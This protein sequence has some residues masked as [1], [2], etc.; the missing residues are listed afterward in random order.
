MFGTV[1]RIQHVRNSWTGQSYRCVAI[2]D[3]SDVLM[4]DGFLPE[5]QVG[6]VVAVQCWLCARLQPVGGSHDIGG[7]TRRPWWRFW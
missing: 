5:L 2:D 6:N 3:R 7:E 4:G 1:R